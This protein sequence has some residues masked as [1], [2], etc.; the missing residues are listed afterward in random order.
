MIKFLTRYLRI[1]LNTLY[2]KMFDING[3]ERYN[4]T[5]KKDNIEELQSTKEKIL[6][7]LKINKVASIRDLSEDINISRDYVKKQLDELV[8]KGVLDYKKISSLSRAHSKRGLTHCD[9]IKKYIN[10]RLYY[11]NKDDLS[12][13]IFSNLPDRLSGHERQTVKMHLKGY[14]IVIDFN[15]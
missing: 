12:D 11:C 15:Y 9:F 5:E 4:I 3:E 6:Y 2:D 13:W 7:Y 8:I 14:G 1:V 10:T